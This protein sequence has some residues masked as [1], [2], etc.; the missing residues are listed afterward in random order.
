MS[1]KIVLVV[2][3]ISLGI[4]FL[5]EIH[6]NGGVLDN[7]E[8]F[9]KKRMDMTSKIYGKTFSNCKSVVSSGS[10]GLIADAA[11]VCNTLKDFSATPWFYY[12][13]YPKNNWVNGWFFVNMDC[14]DFEMIKNDKLSPNTILCKTRQ[15]YDILSKIFPE[16]RVIYTGFTSIDK[17]DRMIPK[18]YSS[19]LHVPGKS[20]FKGT[21]TVLKTWKNNPDW[22]VL[23]VIARDGVADWCSKY[24]NVKN[25]RLILE[26]LPEQELNK[27]SN[28]CGVH[29]CTSEHEGYGHYIHEA[30]AL[31]SVVLYTD[32]P[33]MNESFVDG[34][35]GIAV[36][37]V[38]Q[39]T[40]NNGYCP[41]YKISTDTLKD[42]VNR[43]LQLDINRLEQIGSSARNTFLSENK[44]F[45]Q[46]LK[47]LV[48]GARPIP[49]I[50]HFMWLSK[51]TPYQD[52]EIP[53]KYEKYIKSWQDNNQGFEYIYWS[54]KKILDLIS[55]NLPQYVEYYKS[56]PE[57]ISKCDFAR[58]AIIY[59][60]GGV[61]TD[62]D[63]FCRKNISPLLTGE[64]YF[65]LEPR[66]HFE[67]DEYRMVNGIFAACPQNEFILG[68]L[69]T[70]SKKSK[71]I[72]V[73]QNNGPLGLY[74]YAKQTEN[75][76]LI[77]NTC[78]LLPII[79]N[80]FLAKQCEN[81]YNNYA[82]TIWVDGSGWGDKEKIHTDA[83]KNDKYIQVNNAITG[84][85]IIL[86]KSSHVPL[87][88]NVTDIHTVFDQC[89]NNRDLSIVIDDPMTA[90]HVAHAL[91]NTDTIIVFNS[92]SKSVCDYVEIMALINAIPNIHVTLI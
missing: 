90:I 13:I 14:T 49:H 64:S 78:N 34:I 65:V 68:W 66:E 46:R 5:I 39:D 56:I 6:K 73:M 15:S 53:N 37:Y 28:Q 59:V 77:G 47:N 20:P 11:I 92:K 17:Y 57:I 45:N 79:N 54:G 74:N 83:Y 26:Y 31:G 16:K 85:K 19:F 61:Y 87:K 63:F 58:F 52:V 3:A 25:I 55:E 7:E 36:K 29:I 84:T 23:T 27:I 8:K 69:D 91:K 33:P 75:N 38:K 22:P 18:D 81:E 2:L 42:A 71:F 35:N 70:M 4:F 48:R 30:C 40:F 72:S 86:E 76:V 24:N 32:A 60:Y 80:G 82:S 89:I 44:Q 9:L 67:N 10:Q 41:R 88:Y 51:D 43:V 21:K 62:L 1:I 12:E 50:V